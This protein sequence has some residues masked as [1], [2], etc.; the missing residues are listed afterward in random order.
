VAQ[1]FAVSH[2]TIVDHAACMIAEGIYNEFNK[3]N[4][5][6]KSDVQLDVTHVAR[7]MLDLSYIPISNPS[8]RREIL[9]N[10]NSSQITNLFVLAPSLQEINW[11]EENFPNLEI[12]DVTTVST[13]WFKL[14]DPSA[15][16]AQ[17]LSM[18][19]DAKKARGPVRVSVI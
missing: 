19:L 2:F 4:S 17:A 15:V 8:N 18:F 12:L 13:A 5:S 14:D 10:I 6:S 7:E 1:N 3:A 16:G 11:I 9:N